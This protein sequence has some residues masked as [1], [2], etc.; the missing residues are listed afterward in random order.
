MND[1]LTAVRN[2]VSRNRAKYAFVAGFAACF[3]MT[4][5]ARSQ[6]NEFLDE[7]G[8]TDEFYS[9]EED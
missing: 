5:G 9:L 2:H 3:A 1:K 8:L 4:Q 6:W 7:K